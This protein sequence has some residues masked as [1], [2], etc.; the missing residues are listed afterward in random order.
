MSHLISRN[1]L[2]LLFVF[3]LIFHIILYYSLGTTSWFSVAILASVVDTG[4]VAAL[5]YLVTERKKGVR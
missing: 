2:L 5:Q 1:N 4:I 3:F